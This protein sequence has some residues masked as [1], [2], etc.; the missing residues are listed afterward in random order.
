MKRRLACWMRK[1]MKILRAK[2]REKV[3]DIEQ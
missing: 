2:P 1:P 3:A